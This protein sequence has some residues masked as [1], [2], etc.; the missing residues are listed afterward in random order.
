ML[1]LSPK[2]TELSRLNNVLSYHFEG[3]E[4]LLSHHSNVHV[5]AFFSP[6]KKGRKLY[7]E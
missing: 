2:G 7:R 6:L 3:T 1:G 5:M 4:D